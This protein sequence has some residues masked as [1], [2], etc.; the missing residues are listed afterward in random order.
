MPILH[1]ERQADRIFRSTILLESGRLIS[2]VG[3]EIR[4]QSHANP[5]GRLGDRGHYPYSIPARL[6][7]IRQVH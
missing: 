3:A 7:T 4:E 1:I 2:N 5:T 6:Q